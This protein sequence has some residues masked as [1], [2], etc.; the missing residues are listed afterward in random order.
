VLREGS[1]QGQRAPVRCAAV[2]IMAHS[3]G[4]ETARGR[5]SC[6]GASTVHRGAKRCLSPLEQE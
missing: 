4:D 3:D 5:L 6:E 2:A 1:G